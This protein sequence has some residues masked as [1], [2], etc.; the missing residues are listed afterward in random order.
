MVAIL[1]I[2]FLIVCAAL[3]SWWFSR[4]SLFRAHMRSGADPRAKGDDFGFGKQSPRITSAQDRM[5]PPP[6]RH[7]D[8]K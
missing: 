6:V 4:T 7:Y 8:D 2:V 1:E 5:R 3:G